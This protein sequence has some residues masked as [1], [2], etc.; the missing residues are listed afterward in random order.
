LEL[1]AFAWTPDQRKRVEAVLSKYPVES[2]RCAIAAKRIH[3]IAIELDVD[4]EVWRCSPRYG[5]FVDP[6]RRWF[7]HVTVRVADHYVD[8]LTGADG[9]SAAEYF[10]HHWPDEEALRWEAL[11]SV[12]VEAL[13]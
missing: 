6:Q 3:P 13:R 8:A 7:H 12:Q 5:R 2:A 9:L 11:T 1:V 10:V 4:A